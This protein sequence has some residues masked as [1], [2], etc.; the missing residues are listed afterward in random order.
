MSGRVRV[1][2]RARKYRPLL[3]A[4]EISSKSRFMSLLQVPAEGLEMLLPTEE[5]KA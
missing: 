4:M 5:G 1:A 2:M 3:T